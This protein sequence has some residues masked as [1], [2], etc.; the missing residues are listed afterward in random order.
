ML[1]KIVV[2]ALVVAR[3][4]KLTDFLEVR[5]R[6]FLLIHFARVC[7]NGILIEQDALLG[8]GGIVHR[9]QTS[10][11]DRIGIFPVC[12]ASIIPDH[13]VISRRITHTRRRW[14]CLITVFLQQGSDDLRYLKGALRVRESFVG[15]KL[16]SI[17]EM[18]M[19]VNDGSPTLDSNP[20]DTKKNLLV[21]R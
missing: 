18:S 16:G 3:C 19:E 9:S 15:E 6:V 17:E 12:G 14:R 13:L 8:E 1:Y 4:L 5:K 10:I 11:T 20:V 7:P 21:N 2:R